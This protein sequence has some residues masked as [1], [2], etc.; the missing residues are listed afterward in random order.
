MLRWPILC[1]LTLYRAFLCLNNPLLCLGSVCVIDY[2]LLGY[3]GLMRK[4]NHL[5]ITG[6]L[7]YINISY[8]SDK[9]KEYDFQFQFY[10]RKQQLK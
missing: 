2:S 6:E 4:K 7:K 1:R 10:K 5:E 3:V 8:K 9:L